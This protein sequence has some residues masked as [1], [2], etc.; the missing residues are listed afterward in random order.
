MEIAV[1]LIADN[2]HI[3]FLAQPACRCQ[4][5]LC[6]DSSHRVMGTAQNEELNVMFSDFLFHVVEIHPVSSIF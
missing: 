2:D 4:F 1:D 3:V 6:P 5:I